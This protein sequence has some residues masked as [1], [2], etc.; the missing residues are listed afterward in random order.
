MITHLVALPLRLEIL[1]VL[2]QLRESVLAKQTR[3]VQLGKRLSLFLTIV[4]AIAITVK[5]AQ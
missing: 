3:L 1:R 2:E 5:T 4:L